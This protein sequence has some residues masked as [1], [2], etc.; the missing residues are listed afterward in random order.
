MSM[1]QFYRRKKACPL[2]ETGLEDVDYRDVRLLQKFTSER[3]K[4][5]PSRIT[6]V[7]PKM[8]RKL[9]RA[10]KVARELALLPYLP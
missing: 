2:E 3:G 10:V 9:A 8:Q 1:G 6:S 7:S 5:V 4:I